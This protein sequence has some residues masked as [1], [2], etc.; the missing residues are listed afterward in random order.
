MDLL[1]TMTLRNVGRES[2]QREKRKS[3]KKKKKK[4]NE[5]KTEGERIIGQEL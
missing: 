5:A 3:K 2:R 4:R 1:I